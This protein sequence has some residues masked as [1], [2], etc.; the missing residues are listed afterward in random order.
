MDAR[1][2]NGLLRHLRD[3]QDF[4]ASNV[5]HPLIN[6]VAIAVMAALCG[7][8]G[9]VD[10]ET[11]ARMQAEFLGQFLDLRR[12]IPS[13]D[14]FDRVFRLMDPMAFE[15][16]FH[17]FVAAL[18][19]GSDG[20]FVA[21]DG[22]TLRRSWKRAWSKTPVHMVSAFVAKNHLVLGQLAVEGKSNE[23]TAIPKL[24]ALLSLADRT[25]TIDAIG[26]QRDIIP[27]I[28]AQGGHFLLAVKQNQPALHEKV[29]KLMDEGALEKFKGTRHGMAEQKEQGHGRKERRRLWVCTEVQWL[30]EQ[31]REKWPEIGSLIMVER[32]RQDYGDMEGKSSYERHYYV[33]DHSHTDAKFYMEGIRQHWG[34]ESM[35]WTLDVT[36]KEDDSRL[37]MGNG[38]EAF[39]RLRRLSVTK[40]KNWHPK[41]ENGSPLCTS[42]RLKQKVCNWNPQMLIEVLTA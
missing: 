26:C 12:G 2:T 27:V 32:W 23:I 24:L 3:M 19:E 4:R 41:K 40:H 7:A 17:R 9:W 11:W 33:S 6:I 42:V 10:V 25:V 22:K 21:V 31:L 8:K 13:H 36:M 38:P 39:S 15:A 14:T 35:H 30:G 16:C 37:R 29:K 20:Q 5:S 1:A 18:R 34:I 28:K